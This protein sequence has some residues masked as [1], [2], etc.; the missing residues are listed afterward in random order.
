MFIVGVCE[1]CVY[2]AILSNHESLRCYA[3]AIHKQQH[4]TFLPSVAKSFRTELCAT[5][6]Q[7]YSLPPSEALPFI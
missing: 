3:T 1:F 7:R 6:P 4:N 2:G 5:S